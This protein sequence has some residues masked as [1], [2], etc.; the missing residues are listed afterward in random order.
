[1]REEIKLPDL[2]EESINY[3]LW[4]RKIN[5]V[6]Q[7]YLKLVKIHE[8]WGNSIHIDG[9]YY[10]WRFISPDWKFV[11]STDYYTIFPKNLKFNPYSLS[12]V[13]CI[14]KIMDPIYKLPTRYIYSNKIP[15]VNI[16]IYHHL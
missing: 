5:I 10:N 14:Q 11:K 12:A 16:P 2:I 13:Q 9:K 4:R 3:Y 1:M 6:N 7:Q 15:P 8:F